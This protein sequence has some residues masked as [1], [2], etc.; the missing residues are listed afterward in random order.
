VA[1]EGTKKTKVVRPYRFGD[2]DDGELKGQVDVMRS[3]AV[4]FVT[5]EVVEKCT[6]ASA[7]APRRPS[8]PLRE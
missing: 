3:S 8:L 2:S 5:L 7:W 6:S 1:G 4:T